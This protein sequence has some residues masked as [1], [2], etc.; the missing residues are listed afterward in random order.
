MVGGNNGTDTS[1]TYEAGLAGQAAR[2]NGATSRILLPSGVLGP[3][4]TTSFSIS[5]FVKLDTLDPGESKRVWSFWEGAGTGEIYLQFLNAANSWRFVMVDST[6]AARIAAT[7]TNSA[8][9]NW[10]HLIC[11]Y[12]GATK[13]MSIY[14]DA[15]TRPTATYDRAT[16][17]PTVAYI[18]GRAVAM[19]FDGLI[20]EMRI[21]NRAL[22]AAEVKELYQNP[23]AAVVPRVMSEF[24]LA[25]VAQNIDIDIRIIALR[26]DE[27]GFRFAT[28]EGIS[29][30]SLLSSEVQDVLVPPEVNAPRNDPPNPALSDPILNAYQDADI[31]DGGVPDTSPFNDI[32]DGGVPATPSTEYFGTLG[33]LRP[34]GS[35]M[36]LPGDLYAEGNT[37]HDANI[38]LRDVNGRLIEISRTAGIRIVD[39]VF[40]ERLIQIGAG[41]GILATDDAGETI[42]DIPDVP[43]TAG[44]FSMGHL[45]WFDG[46]ED[47]IIRSGSLA[48]SVWTD[49]T[50]KTG[51]NTNVKGVLLQ[52]SIGD[53]T[54]TGVDHYEWFV[55]FRPKGTSWGTTFAT[56]SAP[57][58]FGILRLT[59]TEIHSYFTTLTVAVP[60]GTDDKIQVFG[61]WLGDLTAADVDVKQLG[62]FV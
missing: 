48:G 62:F 6:A 10:Q 35:A 8:T 19:N 9:T 27:K 4:D 29:E 57:G 42:H 55:F 41:N 49:I 60:I 20:D 16:I 58:S 5:A 23:G 1:I 38:L 13:L 40:E 7:A 43:L 46:S 17:T 36:T 50:C 61:N 22:S 59:T 37:I 56:T 33:E 44:F 34:Q 25:S 54:P 12:N 18:G 21:Y 30:Y 52:V 3:D 45:Y 15:G 47:F 53:A 11:T 39:R 24:N 14:L 51:G 28:A 32:F 2:F 26:E 31:I